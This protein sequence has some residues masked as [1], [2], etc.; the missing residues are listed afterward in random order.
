MKEQ[1]DMSSRLKSVDFAYAPFNAACFCIST[2]TRLY[3]AFALHITAAIGQTDRILERLYCVKKDS[4]SSLNLIRFT[5]ALE[6]ETSCGAYIFIFDL[7]GRF[8]SYVLKKLQ[9]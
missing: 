3:I 7:P 6:S 4:I 8:T 2:T 5:H 9:I 1:F